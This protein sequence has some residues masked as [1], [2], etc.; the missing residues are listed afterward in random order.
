MMVLDKAIKISNVVANITHEANGPDLPGATLVDCGKVRHEKFAVGEPNN[1]GRQS[2]E[3]SSER[4]C[5][6]LDRDRRERRRRCV[7]EFAERG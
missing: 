2:S 5:V 6:V 1:K 3:Q 7:D 4:P